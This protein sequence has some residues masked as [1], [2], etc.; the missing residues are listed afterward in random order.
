MDGGV[1]MRPDGASIGKT[2]P[3]DGKIAS[4]ESKLLLRKS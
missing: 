2:T 1:P 4:E 3:S